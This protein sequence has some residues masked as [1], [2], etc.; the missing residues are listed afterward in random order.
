MPAA[1]RWPQVS[2][3]SLFRIRALGC[4]TPM[5]SG[6]SK[7]LHHAGLTQRSGT[8]RPRIHGLRHRFA[9]QTML[10]AYRQGENAEARSLTTFGM[11]RQHHSSRTGKTRKT[12]SV[13]SSSC[14]RMTGK[15]D[16]I[17]RYIIGY[18]VGY[19]PLSNTCSRALL[20]NPDASAY[21]LLFSFSTPGEKGQFLDLV[22]S[23]EDLGDEYI[24]NDFTSPH[25]QRDCVLSQIFVE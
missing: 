18:L 5:F 21:E 16:C 22:R 9:V 7:C 10:D 6:R 8:C 15:L 17:P 23:N 1:H 11:K 20:D 24:K 2:P 12:G 25:D 14:P 4:H 3:P 19:A 13:R